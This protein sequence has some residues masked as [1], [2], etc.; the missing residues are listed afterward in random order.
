MAQTQKIS[1]NN[2]A[3]YTS[4]RFIIQLCNEG[5][6]LDTLYAETPQEC[7]QRAMQLIDEAGMLFGGDFIKITDTKEDT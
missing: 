7:A 1:K 3:I 6:P 2:T 4:G 5:G